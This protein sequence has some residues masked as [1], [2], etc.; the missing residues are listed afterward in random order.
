MFLPM[1]GVVTAEDV[2]KLPWDTLMLVA[3]GLSLGI[4][5]K[6]LLAPYYS[7]YLA[8]FQFNKF[9]M[10]IIFGF[11]TVLFSNIM[12]STATATI[13]I[14]IAVVVLPV[15]QLLPVALVVGLCSSR[16]LFLPV[17]TPPNAIVFGTG[18]LKQKDF[19]LGGIFG[20]IVGLFISLTWVSVLDNFT[21]FMEILKNY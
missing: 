12:S 16:G 17:S 3:G 5:I 15:S 6:K 20:G 21:P 18:M 9:V 8:D 1:F 7:T 2:R 13:I 14:N 4:A 19:N 11:I 10:M